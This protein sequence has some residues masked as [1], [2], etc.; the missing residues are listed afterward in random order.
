MAAVSGVAMR[1]FKKD[2]KRVGLIGTG[3]QGLYQLIAA[4]SSTSVKTIY[5]C[6]RSAQKIESFIQRFQTIASN[7]IE[8]I[9]VTDKK[10][11]IRN[12]EIIITATTSVSPVLPDDEELY[13][14]K[15]IVG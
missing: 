10:D 2:A 7:G 1:H 3:L 6:N 5:L 11:L 8:I 13:Q 15:L 9:P 12:S 14:N 4:Q